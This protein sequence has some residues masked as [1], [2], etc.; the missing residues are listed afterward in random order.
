M[1]ALM[2]LRSAGRLSLVADRPILDGMA[3]IGFT[4]VARTSD[5]LVL[6]ALGRP[7]R[8]GGG[9]APRLTEQ[10]DPAGFLV[11][12]DTPGWAKMVANFRAAD[13]ELTTET[14]VLLTDD[15]SRR[16]FGRYWLLIRPY[17]GLIRRHWLAGID[18]RAGGAT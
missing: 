5:E 8:V 3:S 12:F 11:D 13:G 6:A 10:P 18:R 16:A 2:L 17:S 9:R 15:R 7:W 14:R 1:R 4:I